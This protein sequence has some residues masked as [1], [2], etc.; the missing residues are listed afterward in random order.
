MPAPD[1]ASVNALLDALGIANPEGDRTHKI[2]LAQLIQGTPRSL[3]KQAPVATPGY[4]GGTVQ[5]VVLPDWFKA[6]AIHRA[7]S[8]AGTVTGELTAQAYGATPATTQIAVAPNGDIQVLATDA[9][10][11]LDLVYVPERLEVVELVVTTGQTYTIPTEYTSRGVVLLQE[12][13]GLAG[14]AGKKNIL[15]PGTVGAAGTAKLNIAKSQ[16]LFGDAGITK[17]RIKLGIAINAP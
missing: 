8:R 10:T 4:H 17:A 15:V 6:A 13:E 3:R 9:I 14:S 2:R 1:Q 12:A 7:T 5:V 11:D 16:V